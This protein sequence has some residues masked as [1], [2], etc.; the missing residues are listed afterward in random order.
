MEQTKDIFGKRLFE[1]RESRGESQQEL[2]DSIGITRQ[3]LSRYEL[4]ERTA[5][6]DLLKKIAK[7]Y[8]VSTDYLLGLT[9]NTTTDIELQAVCD[10]TGLSEDAIKEL[11]LAYEATFNPE[12]VDDLV[13]AE[14]IINY[15]DFLSWLIS[16]GLIIGDITTNCL[17]LKNHSENYLS[18]YKNIC[19]TIEKKMTHGIDDKNNSTLVKSLHN[20][21]LQ[22]DVCRYNLFKIIENLSNHFDQREQVKK[23]GKHNP[24]K[25]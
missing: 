23:N 11:N 22:C 14:Y 8:N 10:Y 19:Q 13:E 18:Q 3:S 21:E 1:I 2:A 16:D 17:D 6:I 25:E 4:G 15:L 24:P 12:A 20:L 7:H 9:E 5:N